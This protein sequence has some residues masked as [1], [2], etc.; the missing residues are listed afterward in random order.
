MANWRRHLLHLIAWPLFVL[1]CLAMQREFA[2]I[3]SGEIR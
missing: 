2:S 1:G 3:L